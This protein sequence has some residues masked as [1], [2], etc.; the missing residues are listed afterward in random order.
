MASD[1]RKVEV[2]M[3]TYNGA[4]Y[5]GRQL[6]SIL[7]QEGVEVHITVRDDGSSDNTM[8]V[9]RHYEESY[10]HRIKVY[11]GENTGCTRCF[12]LLLDLAENADFYAFSDQDDIWD[13]NKLSV[14]LSNICNRSRVLYTSNLRICSE[15]LE[16]MG[17]SS[18]SKEYLSIGSEFARHRYAGC[19][20]VFDKEMKDIVSCFSNLNLPA[21]RMPSHDSL[22]ARCAFACGDVLLDE[23]SHI[24]H[25]RYA[26]SV[27]A[28]GNGMVKRLKTEWKSF[29]SDSVASTTA[30][31]ILDTL[32][33]SIGDDKKCF[34]G[35]IASYK[36]SLKSWVGLLFAGDLDCGIPVC[37]MICRM[38]ILLRRY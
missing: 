15:E 12:L 27:T 28:G 9:L 10:P 34:I 22:I 33:D 36:R 7:H 32:S 5:V 4:K 30:Q 26:G 16:E 19:T 21:G 31:L 37:N 8:E 3:A 1:Y 23:E 29:W 35:R 38:K 14:A 24:S 25:I 13:S 17:R 6:D 18:F 20:Y 11:E 2:M